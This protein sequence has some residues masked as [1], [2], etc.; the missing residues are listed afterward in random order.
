MQIDL[1]LTGLDAVERDLLEL[2]GRA[3]NLRPALDAFVDEALR[4]NARRFASEGGG[5]WPDLADSTVRRRGSAHPI[6]DD[7]GDLRAS[8]TRQGARGS[9]VELTRDSA[10]VATDLFYA[11]FHARRR[12]PVE[13]SRADRTRLVDVV[14]RY[15]ASGAGL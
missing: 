10:V 15:L 1:D 3:E 9:V 6:L 14:E 8:L 5:Q 11:R 7:S 12:P 4:L 2:A 13:Y